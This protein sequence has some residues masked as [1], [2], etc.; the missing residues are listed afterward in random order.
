MQQQLETPTPNHA[1]SSLLFLR[2]HLQERRERRRVD[3]LAA[4]LLQPQRLGVDPV[5]DED[6]AVALV[7]MS[8]LAAM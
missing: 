7:I 8:C 2:T 1:P 4:R 3:G 5:R 6:A